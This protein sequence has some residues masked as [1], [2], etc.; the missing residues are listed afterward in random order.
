M[1][2]QNTLFVLP[3]SC[4]RASAREMLDAGGTGI[5]D[6]R[7]ARFGQAVEEGAVSEDQA[8]WMLEGLEQGYSSMMGRPGF[9]RSRGGGRFQ[10]QRE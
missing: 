3:E 10:P 8:G 7:L 9:G 1:S 6:R 2:R 5:G 4:E